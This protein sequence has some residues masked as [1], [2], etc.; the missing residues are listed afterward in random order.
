MRRSQRS[1]H[2]ALW[3]VL[4]LAIGIGLTFALIWR[5]P[6]AAAPHSEVVR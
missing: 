3:P 5:P 6:P 2:R 1:L 4:V